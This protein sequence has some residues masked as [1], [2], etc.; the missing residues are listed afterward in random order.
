MAC[1]RALGRAGLSNAAVFNVVPT[2]NDPRNLVSMDARASRR[3]F[4]QQLVINRDGFSPAR[5][6]VRLLLMEL[7]LNRFIEPDL[8]FFGYRTC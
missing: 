6:F 3:I 7:A 5:Y 8:F 4:R 1:A 2:A